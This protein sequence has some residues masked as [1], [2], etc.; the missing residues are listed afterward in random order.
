MA[1]QIA[2]EAPPLNG[3]VAPGMFS[4]W[5]TAL[6]HFVDTRLAGSEIRC[7]L[8]PDLREFKGFWQLYNNTQASALEGLTDEQQDERREIL[9]RHWADSYLTSWNLVDRKG[10]PLP[11]NGDGMMALP[12]GGYQWLIIGAWLAG[13]NN[14]DPLSPPASS[15]PDSSEG[16]TMRTESS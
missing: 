12:A 8:S 4:P 11:A 10:E 7:S 3:Q 16:P 1:A 6:L 2:P 9:F 15:A 14:P 5:R 13:V